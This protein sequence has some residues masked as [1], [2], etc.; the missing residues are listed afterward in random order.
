MGHKEFVSSVAVFE[1]HS[2]LL[3]VSGDKELRMW[4]Y[5]TGKLYQI[6]SLPFVPIT[7]IL[8]ELTK[9]TGF[10]SLTDDEDVIHIYTYVIEIE[11][12][13]FNLKISP[14]WQK[15]YSTDHY[16]VSVNNEKCLYVTYMNE[17]E[18]CVDN[19]TC[20]L[21]THTVKV[22]TVYKIKELIG[23]NLENITF[24]K[25][26]ETSLLFKKKYDNV[27]DYHERKRQ[28]ME[29]QMK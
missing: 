24:V 7:L 22:V 15:S 21:E 9:D 19:I 23:I 2:I 1:H 29:K 12:D 27:K 13:K 8:M 5:M 28:R 10:L 17:K 4:N 3:S 18:L 25:S 20:C 14:V 11:S 26:F 16:L 6:L